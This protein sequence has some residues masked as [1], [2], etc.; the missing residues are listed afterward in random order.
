MNIDWTNPLIKVSQHFSVQEA[1]WLPSW[2][3][4]A[5]E[6]DGLNDAV[7]ANLITLMNAMDQVR[8]FLDKPIKVHVAYRPSAYNKQIGGATHSAH[9]L[10]LAMDFD[11]GE[12]CD[13]TRAALLPM[14]ETWGMRMEKK[15]GSNW[16]HLDLMPPNPNRYF[17]P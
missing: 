11:A 9:V 17:I 1:L 8:D 5:N 2:N 3:R 13:D 6:D 14:L 7:K 12:D 16:I 15:D 10:G 4:M